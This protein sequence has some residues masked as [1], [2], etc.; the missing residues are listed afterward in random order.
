MDELEKEDYEKILRSWKGDKKPKFNR[1]ALSNAYRPVT[2]LAY[3]RTAACEFNLRGLCDALSH[4]YFMALGYRA[5]SKVELQ[6]VETLYS[7]LKKLYGTDQLLREGRNRYYRNDANKQM[8]EDLDIDFDDYVENEIRYRSNGMNLKNAAA[9]I[10]DDITTIDV[11][12]DEQNT[13]GTYTFKVLKSLA[14]E[15]EE[16][17]S[18]VLLSTAHGIKVG[19]V[20]TIHPEPKIDPEGATIKWAFQKVDTGAVDKFAKE[21]AAVEDFL[22]R[23]KA[24]NYRDQI[25]GQF[26]LGS[27][28]DVKKLIDTGKLESDNT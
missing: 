10:R 15:L 6:E 21:D 4:F 8:Y 20:Q 23:R 27:Y 16:K 5:V 17:K 13:R 28:E 14:S 7:I 11:V 22:K 1:T 18:K 2:I 19:T 3:V 12:H 26:G 25:L 9:L 24:K